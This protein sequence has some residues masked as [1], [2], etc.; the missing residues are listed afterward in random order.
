MRVCVGGN[1]SDE[2]VSGKHIPNVV[3]TDVSKT[4]GSDHCIEKWV[5]RVRVS[6][7]GG[8]AGE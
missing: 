5:D 4:C 6:R 2:E 1:V 3:F 8:E 7:K